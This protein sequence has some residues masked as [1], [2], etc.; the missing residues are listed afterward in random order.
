[1]QVNSVAEFLKRSAER[2]GF[3]RDRFEERKIPTDYSNVC[4]LPFFGDMRGMF[5]LSTF[6]LHRFR[7]EMRGSKYF[8]LASWPGYQG[9]FPQADEYW[10]FD[11]KSV[12]KSFYETAENLRNVSDYNTTYVRNF[13]E[14]FR[15]VITADELQKYY[16]GTFTNN[17]F[18]SFGKVKRFFPFVP[19]ASVLGRDFNKEL[20][21][22]PGYKIFIHPSIYSKV[23]H[24][25][26][27]QNRKTKKEFWKELC[28]VLIQNRMTPVIWQNFNSW[29]LYEEFREKCIFL[30]DDDVV[31]ALA[32][33]RA[34]SCVLDVFNGLSRYAILARTPFVACDERSRFNGLNESDVDDICANKIPKKYIFSFSTI[35][36][37]G[38]ASFWSQDIFQSILKKLDKFLPDLNRDELLSTA[39]SNE[40]LSYGDL[41]RER[42]KKKF[43]IRF[44][45]VEKD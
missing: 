31:K 26:L 20:V 7:E 10:S 32:A 39:E 8:V 23:W 5:T 17:F 40:L 3:T 33:M 4:I 18:E 19:S 45:K 14:F 36:T 30:R 27:S 22:K 43:G 2:N 11:D 42:K 38:S 1:M 21:A 13:N 24:F 44:I 34:S 29:D 28:N 35:I 41:V 6:L 16:R 37:D 9:L 12:I 15:D 25:G